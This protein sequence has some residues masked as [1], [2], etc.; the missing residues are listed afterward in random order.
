M[1]DAARRPTSY[2]GA[3]Y[4][5]GR[6]GAGNERFAA[7]PA[8]AAPGKAVAVEG[9]ET[10]VSLADRLRGLVVGLFKK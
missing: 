4:H 8:V 2:D 5:V 6:G 10:T 1:P 9:G 7:T 3:D